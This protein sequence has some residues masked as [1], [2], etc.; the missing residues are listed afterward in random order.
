MQ[1][2]CTRSKH[3]SI[4]L[5]SPPGCTNGCQNLKELKTCSVIVF[6]KPIDFSVFC[7][8]EWHRHQSEFPNHLCHLCSFYYK[9]IY[10]PMFYSFLS[11]SHSLKLLSF[12][13]SWVQHPFYSGPVLVTL[14]RCR[15]LHQHLHQP[16]RR[17]PFSGTYLAVPPEW[18]VSPVA[19]YA[20]RELTGSLC[21]GPTKP[22]LV[23]YS[24][25]LL[26][27]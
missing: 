8:H 24:S 25:E 2:K 16:A 15:K 5:D 20:L 23:C 9:A 7:L 19:I 11:S 1:K 18:G 26:A 13:V 4:S 12:P 21:Y 27:D 10:L 22:L 3:S 14:L 17:W 6:P